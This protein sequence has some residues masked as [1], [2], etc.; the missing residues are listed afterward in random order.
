[1]EWELDGKFNAWRR[2]S[3]SSFCY[4][5]LSVNH[6]PETVFFNPWEKMELECFYHFVGQIIAWKAIAN[7]FLANIVCVKA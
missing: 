1:M 6:N 2:M 4:L 3:D 7:I 5:T